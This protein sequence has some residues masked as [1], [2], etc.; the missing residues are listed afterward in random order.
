MKSSFCV[1]MCLEGQFNAVLN[2]VLFCFLCIHDGVLMDIA[3]GLR[4]YKDLVGSCN[5]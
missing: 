5:T 3:K 4:G 1:M 2:E